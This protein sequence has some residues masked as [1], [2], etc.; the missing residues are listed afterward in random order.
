[1]KRF[2]AVCIAAV[3]ALSMCSCSERAGYAKTEFFAMNTYVSILADGANDEL[4]RDIKENVLSLE[5]RY[6]RTYENSELSSLRSGVRLQSDT[7]ELL[8]ELLNLS[9]NT[10]GAFD[11]TFGA[12]SELW[13]ITGENP[14]VPSRDR[15]EETLSHCGYQKVRIDEDGIFYCDDEEMKLDLGAA[16]KGYAGQ[17]QIETLRREG[18]E[19]AAVNLG[20][21][22]SVIGSSAENKKKGVSGWSIGINNPFDTSELLGTVLLSD[23]TISVS[24]SYERYFEEDGM[25]YHHILDSAT[26]YPADSGLISVAVAARD[27]LYADALS[28]ALFVLGVDG[29]LALY[30]EKLYDFEAIFCSEDGT[31]TVTPGLETD[32][33][34]NEKAKNGDG[35]VLDFVFLSE[36]SE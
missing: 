20:G 22:V 7:R 18:I 14:H 30:A 27:G 3:L 8:S 32:F 12:L 1:M 9:E 2:L 25:R 15:I 11:F 17:R 13:D 24:G 5:K 16:V 31:V 23:G 26:G 28:T 36:Q 34:P 4:L 33:L 6:S 35:K 29:G 19:N 10:Q 21:N